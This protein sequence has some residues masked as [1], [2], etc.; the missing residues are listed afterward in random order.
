MFPSTSLPTVEHTT[1][2]GQLRRQPT[3]TPGTDPLQLRFG[4]THRL[5]HGLRE[6]AAG[7]DWNLFTATY[8]PQAEVRLHNL[9]SE[10]LRG[11]LFRYTADRVHTSKTDQ[12]R[13]TTR[14]IISTGPA[15]ACT[16]LLAEVGR[17]V[18]I[19]SFHQ[20]EIFE[21]TVTF[22]HVT[23]SHRSRWAVGFGPNRDISVAAAL[24]SAGQRIHG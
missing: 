24:S 6:E 13:I 11:G 18:E 17:H 22:L 5:P 2:T 14:E 23:D 10:R 19:L 4:G 21:A 7:M 8:A 3:Q 9:N 1:R 16:G 12:P 20:L 15:S